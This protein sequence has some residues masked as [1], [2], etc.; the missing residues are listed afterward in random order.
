MIDGAMQTHSLTLNRFLE[1]AAKW[2]PHSGVATG[3]E[4]GTF[5]SY[6]DILV[7]AH[8]VSAV[9]RDRGTRSIMSRCGMG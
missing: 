1:H 8:K 2:H 7:R 9:L 4:N 5:A 3:G 6:A